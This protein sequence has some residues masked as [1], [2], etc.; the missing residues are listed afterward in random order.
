[1]G[2]ALAGVGWLALGRDHRQAGDRHHMAP[3]RVSPV[4]E[5]EESRA[6][7]SARCVTRRTRP[8]PRAVHRESAVGCAPDSQRASEVGPLAKPVDG[9]QVHA[10]TSTSPVTDVANVPHEPREPDHGRRPLRR[11]DHHI[12]D[13]L[14][15]RHPRA[16]ASKD[17]SPGRHRPSHNCLDGTAASQRLSR[18]RG[19]RVSPA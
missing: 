7:R 3:A 17:R 9:R 1:V 15:A 16:R 13:A 11:A 12:Q 6:E 10:A 5:V 18:P 4:L 19:A 14:R 8:D 2:L